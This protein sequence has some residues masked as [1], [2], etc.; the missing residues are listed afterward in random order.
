MPVYVRP[1][2]AMLHGRRAALHT[3]A[4]QRVPYHALGL[5]VYARCDELAD[6]LADGLMSRSPGQSVGEV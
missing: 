6:E 3:A 2:T 1:L 4:G 5:P